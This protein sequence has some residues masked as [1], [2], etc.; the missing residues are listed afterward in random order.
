DKFKT[1]IDKPLAAILT[2][3]TIAN[4]WCAIGVGKEATKIWP[5][6]PTI[7]GLIV[8]LAMTA[9]I[10]IFSEIT[11]KTL[12]AKNWKTLAPFTARSVNF[13]LVILMPIIWLLQVYTRLLNRTGENNIFSRA[14]FLA[15]AEIGS[16]EGELDKVESKL[17]YN[18]L[19]FKNF[20]V[21]D[22]MTPRSV[23]VSEPQEMYAREF[24]DLQE[25]LIFSRILLKE[26]KDS[27]IIIGYIL[28]DEVLEHLLD[29]EDHKQ[30]SH[31]KRDII[32]VSETYSM[33]D[34]LDEFN[35]VAG[36]V[37][38]EDVIET[39]LGH[40]IVDET[41]KVADLQDLAIQQGQ[42]LTENNK[43]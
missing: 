14:D 40:E 17:I 19:H 7:T 30:L 36:V 1:N 41:D 5:N 34:V 42:Q 9:C 35:S 4:T 43:A 24:Y 38:M 10:L 26:S 15:M 11:P 16:I 31:F 23:I 6:Y 27:E 21:K 8:P 13:L 28:K 25:E 29:D 33:L 18:L 22:V 3:N 12:G 37:T 20:Q 32:T 2:L 39:I